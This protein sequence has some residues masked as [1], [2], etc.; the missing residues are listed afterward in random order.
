MCPQALGESRLHASSLG[1]L[2]GSAHMA[3]VDFARVRVKAPLSEGAE[4][5]TTM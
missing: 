3:K 2:L 4:P 5:L 1:W